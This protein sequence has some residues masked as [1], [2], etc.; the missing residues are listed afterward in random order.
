MMAALDEA[1][2]LVV[3]SDFTRRQYIERGVRSDQRFLKINPGVDISLF[4]PDAGDPAAVRRTYGLGG[5]PT[6]LSVARLVEWKGQD[7]VLRALPQLLSEVPD[8]KYLIVGD[9]PF[10][11]D[12]ER[13]VRELGLEEHVAFAGHVPEQELPSY[14]RA[15]DVLVVPSREFVEHAPVEGFG[16]V[17][18]EAGACGVPVVGGRSGGTEES[19][20][21]GVTG[22]RVDHDDPSAVAEVTARLL[23]DRALAERIGKAGRERAVERFDWAHQAERLRGFLEDV[24]GEG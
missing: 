17:Y 19:I 18:V 7:T 2:F 14:Y 9:G 13:L 15:G 20:E 1:D 5:R 23:R 21:Q 11:S 12:L 16:I 3:N 4:R 8:A 24:V 6:L 10:R 22:Y